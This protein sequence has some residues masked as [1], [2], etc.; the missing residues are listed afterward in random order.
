[1]KFIPMTFSDLLFL[2]KKSELIFLPPFFFPCIRATRQYSCYLSCSSCSWDW[3]EDGRRCRCYRNPLRG[4]FACVDWKSYFC[5]DQIC[6]YKFLPYHSLSHSHCLS[7]KFLFL[8]HSS[9]C[10][11]HGQS[12]TH[13]HTQTHTHTCTHTHTRAYRLHFKIISY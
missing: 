3:E 12:Q 6:V 9:L 10:R 5:T 7:F 1:M 13:K 2:G 11:I 4:L 8:P